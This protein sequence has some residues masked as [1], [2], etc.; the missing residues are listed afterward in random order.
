M[1]ENQLKAEESVAR[2][3]SPCT[4]LQPVFF[5]IQ[6]LPSFLSS[7]ATRLLIEFAHSWEKLE[8]VAGRCGR[9]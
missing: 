1:K 3:H 7:A 5:D 2:I 6:S 9:V 8:E 4:L